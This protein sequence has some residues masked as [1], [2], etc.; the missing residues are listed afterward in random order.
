MNIEKFIADRISDPKQDKGNISKPIVKIGIIGIALGVSIMFLT[1]SIVLGFKKEIVT[2]ITGLTTDL[3]VSNINVN[4][5]NEPEPITLSKDTL[6]IIKKLPFVNY[7][8]G[9]AF[10]NGILK[11]ETENEGVILKGINKDYNFNFI[12]KYMVD[13]RLPEFKK[14][15]AS[16]DVLISSSLAEKLN[17]KVNEKMLVYFI[18]QHEVYDSAVKD[19]VVKYEQRSRNFTIC[20]VFKTSFSDF[21]NSLSF[22]DLRQIQR[23]NYW[24]ENQV[25]NYEIRIK[26]FEKLDANLETVQDLLGYDYNVGSVKQI[27]SNIFIWLEKL[28]INGIIIIVLMVIVATINMITALLILI[29]ERTNMVGLVKALGMSNTNVRK[30]FLMISLKLVGK[31]LLWGNVFGIAACLL[32]QYFKI[33]KLDSSIY[34]VEYVAVDINWL[35]FLGLNI[36]TFVVC[37]LMLLLPTLII[38]KL[39]PIKTLKFD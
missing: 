37:F 11:T 12:K 28:D 23:L 17:L 3:V 27:Y 15:E 1:V 13:G 26:D 10:K 34:Y 24:N 32:Q 36:G 20:G 22:V 7:L 38:T 4:A 31:G 29:L 35:Y 18:S 39:T 25:G 33:V 2:R 6:E 14:H 30:I 21:D 8:Q 16:K 5:S 9:T 19:L